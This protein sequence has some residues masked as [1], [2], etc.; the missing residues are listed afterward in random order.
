MLLS[1]AIVGAKPSRRSRCRTSAR[2]GLTNST[3]ANGSVFVFGL[4]PLQSGVR[5]RFCQPARQADRRCRADIAHWPA[6]G[7]QCR[8]LKRLECP[9]LGPLSAPSR[10]RQRHR[11][12]HRAAA[13]GGSAPDAVYLPVLAVHSTRHQAAANA[14]GIRSGSDQWS[15]MIP[16]RARPDRAHGSPPDRFDTKPLRSRWKNRLGKE[17]GIPGRSGLCFESDSALIGRIGQ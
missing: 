7:L 2:S 5:H 11:V 16:Y 1:P 9:G 15:S 4:T 8:F 12:N 14:A 3:V 13:N 6:A 10:H 17:S